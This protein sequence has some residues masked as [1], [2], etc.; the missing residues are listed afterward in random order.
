MREFQAMLDAIREGFVNKAASACPDD[1]LERANHLKAFG[2][3][4]DASMVAVSALAEEARLAQS[5]RNADIDS[6]ADELRTRQT[7]TLAA[8]LLYTSPSPRD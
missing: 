7:L 5:V 1:P 8:C 2:Y 6:L 4:N 3:F